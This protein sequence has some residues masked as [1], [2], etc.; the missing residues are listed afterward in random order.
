MSE[1]SVRLDNLI[2]VGARREGVRG[3]ARSI[4]EHGRTL[5]HE[6]HSWL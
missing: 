4:R 5:P 3:M 2:L 6:V 1:R